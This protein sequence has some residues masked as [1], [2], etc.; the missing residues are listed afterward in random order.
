M[1]AAEPELEGQELWPELRGWKLHP[2]WLPAFARP[3][4]TTGHR[5]VVSMTRGGYGYLPNCRE[6]EECANK[7]MHETNCI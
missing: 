2:V 5:V 7:H 1:V 6:E 4:A 3:T